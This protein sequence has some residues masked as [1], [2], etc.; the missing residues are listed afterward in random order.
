MKQNEMECPVIAQNATAKSL[1][2]LIIAL[3]AINVSSKWTII[4]PGS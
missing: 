2:G 3:Y 4:V 1:I